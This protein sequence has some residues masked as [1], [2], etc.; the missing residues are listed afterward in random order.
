[1]FAV[2][3]AL[4]APVLSHH[5][6]NYLNRHDFL[7]FGFRDAMPDFSNVV[8]LKANTSFI[9][10]ILNNMYTTKSLFDCGNLR[11]VAD[12]FDID[13]LTW[14]FLVFLGFLA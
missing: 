9:Y 6:W 3:W 2:F 5:I 1:M 4:L 8:E 13:T 12:L 11:P 14:L 7:N 10:K